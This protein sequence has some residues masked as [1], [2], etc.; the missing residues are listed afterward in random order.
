MRLKAR[1]GEKPIRAI[2]NTAFVSQSHRNVQI[3]RFE[4]VKAGWE[5]WILL[6]SDLHLDS[7]HCN[8]KLL[9]KHLDMAGERG[10]LILCAGDFVDAMQGKNDRRNSKYEL[11]PEFAHSAP[12]SKPY[13]DKVVDY[14]YEFIK[15]Y[16]DLWLLLG[17]GNHET[18][19]LKNNET[20]ITERV[21][22]RM[23]GVKDSITHAGGYGGFVRFNFTVGTAR[24]SFT[25]YYH[26]GKGGAPVM[27]HG[28]LDT[29]RQGSY[30]D[31]D[32]IH[33]GHTHTNYHLSLRKMCLSDMGVPQ[34][35]RVDYVRT[36][37]YQDNYS[38]G[39]RGFAVETNTPKPLGA[40][41]IQLRADMTS[42]DI[43]RR[44]ISEFE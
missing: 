15:P 40:Y 16:A 20:D 38:D 31:A 1:D 12:N 32:V 7:V 28:S 35:K 6:L 8:Q 2:S 41:W 24:T 19:V 14:A 26:H 44:F 10:A 36:P 23:R 3:V 33:N 29:R 22:E 30:V 4:N 39:Y 17:Q 21:V 43:E 5:Q 13:F 27:S 42:H 25:Y 9:K 37:G 18:A 11:R 34:H